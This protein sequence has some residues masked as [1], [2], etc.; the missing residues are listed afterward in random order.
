M[1]L[2][3]PPPH[4]PTP[5]SSFLLDLLGMSGRPGHVGLASGGGGGVNGAPK[6]WGGGDWEKGSVSQAPL[7]SYY[8]LLRRIEI[9]QFFFSPNIWQMMTFLNPLDAL[10]PKIPFPF[11]ADFRVWVTSEAR[12]SVS[13]GFWGSCQLS[14]FWGRGCLARGLYQPPPAPPMHCKPG[15]PSC[16]H[17]DCTW[18]DQVDLS[19]R[20]ILCVSAIA[21]S[22]GPDPIVRHAVRVTGVL[23][24]PIF[25]WLRTALKDRPQ[26]PPLPTATDRQPPT[27]NPHQPP[28][29]RH[30]PPPTA[31][32]CHQPPTANR[33]QA[34]FKV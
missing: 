16:I 1:G 23:Q 9:G 22:V 20:T 2:R 26:G 19:M 5:W 31:T 25:F 18:L 11:F 10:I 7:V 21:F 14:P 12:G 17:V 24:E 34:R 33:H 4:T 30:Q 28:I 15:C 8:E 6:I 27:T 29:A 13:V 32:D 3:A